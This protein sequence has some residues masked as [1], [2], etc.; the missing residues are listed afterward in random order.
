MRKLKKLLS[1]VLSLAV[2]FTFIPVINAAEA[3]S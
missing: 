1:G 3:P 2:L